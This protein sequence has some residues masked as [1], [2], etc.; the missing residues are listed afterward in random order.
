[1]FWNLESSNLVAEDWNFSLRRHGVKAIRESDGMMSNDADEERCTSGIDEALE[2]SCK[3]P[4]ADA[5]YTSKEVSCKDGTPS[6]PLPIQD[7]LVNRKSIPEISLSI[8]DKSPL[9]PNM[10][11]VNLGTVYKSSAS[12]QVVEEKGT[13]VELQDD[14]VVIEL[15]MAGL[16]GTDLHYKKK[17]PAMVRVRKY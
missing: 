5:V 3:H 1:V 11:S 12:G 17:Q 9:L 16:C 10:P 6:P 7:T 4:G 2:T 14:S 15:L 8:P 13:D